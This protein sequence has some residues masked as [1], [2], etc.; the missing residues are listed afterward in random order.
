MHKIFGLLAMMLFLDA[1]V[2][3]ANFCGPNQVK[4]YAGAQQFYSTVSAQVKLADWGWVAFE[5]EDKDQF[6]LFGISGDS[7]L[8]CLA[9]PNP[10]FGMKGRFSLEK[11]KGSI[12]SSLLNK[13]IEVDA[14]SVS[15]GPLACALLPSGFSLCGGALIKSTQMEMLGF[16]VDLGSIS[17]VIVLDKSIKGLVFSLEASQAKYDMSHENT[18]LNLRAVNYSLGLGFEY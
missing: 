12:H 5:E 4:A 16:N 11:S 1:G 2:A 17:P 14:F 6:S 9:G 8:N 18:E 13:D 7:S 15:A 3:E 10:R